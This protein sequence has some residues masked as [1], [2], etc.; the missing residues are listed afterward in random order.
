M[1]LNAQQHNSN[2]SPVTVVTQPPHCLTNLLA[3][4]G[5][6]YL[7]PPRDPYLTQSHPSIPL[8]APRCYICLWGIISTQSVDRVPCFTVEKMSRAINIPIFTPTQCVGGGVPAVTWGDGENVSNREGSFPTR[9]AGSCSTYYG[10]SVSTSSGAT[11]PLNPRPTPS[12]ETQQHIYMWIYS[13]QLSRWDRNIYF[14]FWKIVKL[15]LPQ[16]NST[17]CYTP[18]RCR[19]ITLI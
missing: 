18:I 16:F 3:L 17:L 6:L 10:E 7:T 14:P 4:Q 5:A 13:K 15:Q 2:N 8:I 9:G 1:R 11:L 12:A 19:W